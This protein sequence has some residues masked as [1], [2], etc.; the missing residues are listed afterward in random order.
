MVEAEIFNVAYLHKYQV[1]HLIIFCVNKNHVEYSSYTFPDSIGTGSIFKMPEPMVLL[2]IPEIL[3]K[4]L[5][6]YQ[7][8]T[9]LILFH[10]LTF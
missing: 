7:W 4:I 5:I 1:V 6:R 10:L 9:C 3:S 8:L 2:S